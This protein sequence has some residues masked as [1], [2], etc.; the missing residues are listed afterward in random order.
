MDVT[1]ESEKSIAIIGMGFRLPGGIS[2]DGEFW[3]LLINKKNGRCKVPLTRYNVDGFGGGKTQ[4]QSVATEYGYFLQNK[5]SG[6]DTSFFSMKHAEV[7]VLDPQLRLLLEVAWECMESAGQTHK[8]V[9]SNTGVFAGVFGEDWHNML[10]R[11]D[12]MPNTYRVLSAGDYGLSNVLS[13]QYDF[14]GPR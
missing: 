11:D 1:Q 12:L 4:T 5:L 10:H 7:N 6:V 2:T 13:Y 9:G 3:D 8:L 14:R